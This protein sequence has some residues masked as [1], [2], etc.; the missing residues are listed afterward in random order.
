MERHSIHDK[1]SIAEVE[2]A[3]QRGVSA[4]AR[5]T[6]AH[7]VPSTEEEQALDRRFNLKFDL[8]IIPSC[9]WGLS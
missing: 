2:V 1:P 8:C 5:S 9:H 7:Y 6:V 4:Q 3:K